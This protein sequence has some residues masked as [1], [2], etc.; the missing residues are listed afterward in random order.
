M[1]VMR[2]V[3][4]S[5]YYVI[6]MISM[7]YTMMTAAVAVFMGFFMSFATV[8]G[9]ALCSICLTYAQLM[10]V[11]VSLVDKVKVAVMEI[12]HMTVVFDSQVSTLF[13]VNVLVPFMDI[14]THSFLLSSL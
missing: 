14:T 8:C 10:L 4:M 5:I 11:N 9:R 12:V 7:W 1:S 3:K 6:D 13:S 2:I